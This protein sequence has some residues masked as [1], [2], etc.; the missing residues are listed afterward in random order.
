MVEITE[1][2]IRFVAEVIV[3]LIIFSVIFGEEGIASN[4]F[5]YLVFAEPILL[6]DY[7]SSALT[8]GSQAPGEF[9]SSVKTSGQPHTI[10]IY[11][12]DGITYVHVIPAQEIYLK[13]KFVSIDPIPIATNCIIPDQTIKLQKN[14]IQTITVKKTFEEVC[15]SSG[16][17]LSCNLKLIA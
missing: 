4:T 2:F 15:T 5:N 16:C 17:T 11:R 6:Q 10:E 12:R 9:S 3:L 13:T 7:L 1:D 14:L 8:I